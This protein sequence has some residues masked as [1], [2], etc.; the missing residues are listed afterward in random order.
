MD[1]YFYIILWCD[2]CK[3]N[4]PDLYN[5][6]CDDFNSYALKIYKNKISAEKAIEIIKE[7]RDV[8]CPNPSFMEQ[9]KIFYKNHGTI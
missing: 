3:L 8:A 4:L 7:K 5:Q 9:L 6:K 1:D 2:A